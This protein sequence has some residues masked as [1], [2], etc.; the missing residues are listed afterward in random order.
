MRIYFGEFDKPQKTL[1]RMCTDLGYFE[2]N[3]ENPGPVAFKLGRIE[4]L[5]GRFVDDVDKQ[6]QLRDRRVNDKQHS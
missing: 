3:P 2:V 1:S 4:I 6:E 5:A